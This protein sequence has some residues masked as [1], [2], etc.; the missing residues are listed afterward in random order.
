MLKTPLIIGANME[1]CMGSRS[2]TWVAESEERPPAIDGIVTCKSE[3]EEE[4][5]EEEE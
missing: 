3:V 5:T 1:L 4:V 2:I